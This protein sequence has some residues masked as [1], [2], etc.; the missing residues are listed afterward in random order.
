MGRHLLKVSRWGANYYAEGPPRAEVSTALIL[1]TNTFG[2]C[3]SSRQVYCNFFLFLK[4]NV[5]VF[6]L[7]INACLPDL[8]TRVEV[9]IILITVLPPFPWSS[10][11]F[12][13][14]LSRVFTLSLEVLWFCCFWFPAA[15]SRAPFPLLTSSH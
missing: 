13:F 12:L 7:G 2:S 14:P 1:G 3:L 4:I 10:A 5:L 15:S 9:F 6:W 8:C 11:C